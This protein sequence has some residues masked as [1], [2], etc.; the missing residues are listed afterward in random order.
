[1][2]WPISPWTRDT[3]RDLSKRTIILKKIVVSLESLSFSSVSDISCPLHHLLEVPSKCT[4]ELPLF[5]FTIER[6]LRSNQ[7]LLLHQH[8]A[9]T[10][11]LVPRAPNQ[12]TPTSSRRMSEAEPGN[13]CFVD[14]RRLTTRIGG[15]LP[16]YTTLERLVSSTNNDK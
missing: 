11:K 3:I 10:E 9:Y 5:K 7:G 15:L 4:F 2:R 8:P 6:R 16:R 13:R 12:Y 1:M 14:Q